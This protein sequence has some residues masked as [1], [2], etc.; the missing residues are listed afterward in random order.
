MSLDTCQHSALVCSMKLGQAYKLWLYYINLQ[1]RA[2]AHIHLVLVEG[3]VLLAVTSEAYGPT[4]C[5]GGW[6]N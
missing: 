5:V 2:A 4:T 3:F 6:V 1:Q